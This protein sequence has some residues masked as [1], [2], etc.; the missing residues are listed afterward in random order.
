MRELYLGLRQLRYEDRQDKRSKGDP[1]TP[2]TV[3]RREGADSRGFLQIILPKIGRYK[4]DKNRLKRHKFGD[5]GGFVVLRW[6]RLMLRWVRCRGY[7]GAA[8]M[9]VLQKSANF[10]EFLLRS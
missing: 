10:C 6:V 8:K 4:G 1:G 9:E 5:L 3:S 2:G 7:A